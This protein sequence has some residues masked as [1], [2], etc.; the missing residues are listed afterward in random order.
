MKGEGDLPFVDI[1]NITEID[2]ETEHREGIGAVGHLPTQFGYNRKL[3]D[4][5]S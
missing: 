3:E 4:E 1:P 2:K 5:G